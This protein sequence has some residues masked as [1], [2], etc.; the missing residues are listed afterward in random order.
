MPVDGRDD[1]IDALTEYRYGSLEML[2]TNDMF[3]IKDLK[4]FDDA[5]QFIWYIDLGKDQTA[6]PPDTSW[7]AVDTISLPDPYTGKPAYHAV[8]YQTF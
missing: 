7:K 6:T 5:H 8:R 3:K 4:A 1:D 2:R